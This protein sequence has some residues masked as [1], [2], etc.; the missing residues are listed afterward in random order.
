MSLVQ[1]QP[2]QPKPLLFQSLPQT[3]QPSEF[4]SPGKSRLGRPPSTSPRTDSLP[5]KALKWRNACTPGLAEFRYLQLLGD[6]TG[7]DVLVVYVCVVGGTF[8][9]VRTVTS[10]RLLAEVHA[11]PYPWQFRIVITPCAAGSV[12]VVV[13]V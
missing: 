3:P 7:P 12:L 5:V 2:P 13:H 11:L 8:G 1:I 10:L 4:V 9:G 6:I